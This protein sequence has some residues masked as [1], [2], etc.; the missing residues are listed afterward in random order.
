MD[1][2]SL[3]DRMK[4]Y[5]DSWQFTLPPRQPII[6]RVDGKAFHTF[7]RNIEKPFSEAF[8]DAMKHA[9][10]RLCEEIQNTQLAYV[11]SDEISVLM[12]P[13]KT[14]NTDPWFGN[15]I[16]KIASVSAAI[17]TMAFYKHIKGW[18]DHA[19]PVFDGRAFMLPKDEVVNY[20][21]WRQRDWE[22]NSVQM[23]A[24]S[25][26]S[27]KQLD[28]RSCDNMKELLRLKAGVDWERLPLH[29]KHG[30]FIRKVG[31]EGDRGK[32]IEDN[33]PPRIGD[34][35]HYIEAHINIEEQD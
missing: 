29:L 3:G 16:Q 23:F 34:A 12:T 1:K 7:T 22:R 4:L 13:Y 5:E 31:T 18:A 2:T 20:F 28:K 6:I 30:T 21:I 27:H 33:E 35:R 14:Y 15:N 10:W 25:H 11:Q 24:R 17:T 32:F 8:I 26:F 9:A 19:N